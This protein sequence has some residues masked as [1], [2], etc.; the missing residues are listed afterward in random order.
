MKY[1]APL[2]KYSVNIREA[3]LGQGEKAIKIGGENTFPFH[4]LTTGRA[5]AATLRQGDFTGS[6][7]IE[8]I[9]EGTQGID[10]GGAGGEVG[11]IEVGLEGDVFSLNRITIQQ[12]NG[13]GD[14]FSSIRCFYQ[15]YF[16]H[17]SLLFYRLQTTRNIK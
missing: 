13:A 15:T 14:A 8:V 17:S 1:E 12:F 10:V 4:Y 6:H 7:F 3:V 9:Y 2:E 16:R 11:G 5:G